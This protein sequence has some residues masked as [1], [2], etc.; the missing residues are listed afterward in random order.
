MSNATG[1][2]LYIGAYILLIAAL[3]PWLAAH[4]AQVINVDIAYLTLSAERLLAGEAMSEAYYDTNPPLSIILQIP[5]VI[6]VKLTHLPLYHAVSAYILLL[7]AL[8][9]TATY[10]LLQKITR[11]SNEQK[12]LIVSASL[13]TN[14]V[15]SG[16]DFGQKDHILAMALLPLTLLQILITQRINVHPALKWLT[17]L[18]GS[19]LILLKPHYGIIPA[20]IFLHR[21][22]T[23]KRLTIFK[24][25]DFLC[26]TLMAIAYIASIYIFFPDFISVIFP[27]IITFYAAD[28]SG[29]IV[30]T[31][32]LTAL[33]P[34][35][36][37]IISLL[38]FKD[39]P[40]LIP[41]I[42]ILSAF[43]FIPFIMQGKG[44][45]YHL[46]PA[47]IFFACGLSVL[48][49][50][51]M[52]AILMDIKSDK[53]KKTAS[54]AIT[55]IAI[56]SLA[57]YGGIAEK[58][59]PTHNEFRGLELTNIIEECAIDNK[60]NCPFLILHDMIN[61]SQELSIYTGQPHASRFPVMWFTPYL[62]NKENNLTSD[63]LKIYTDK[64]TN[65]IA[66]DFYKYSPEIIFVAHFPLPNENETIF[67]YRDYLLKN[68]PEF[69]NIWNNYDFQRT[70][71]IDRADYMGN[72]KPN[73]KLMRYDI[74]IRR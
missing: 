67:N 22:Y 58:I 27:D 56:L 41:S 19:V 25:H 47:I 18:A 55:F 69:K 52:R 30:T 15:A 42:F 61:I 38:I 54:F 43:C 37:S 72:K 34:L 48:F 7:L 24:D 17:L 64:Y 9:T 51:I 66:Q 28:I 74:Y 8:S 71:S 13:V 40:K 57:I 62:I 10:L 29:D 73:E 44:W 65:M 33:L 16:Y 68:N 3:L 23:Q 26:L 49:E 2:L 4:L 6:L 60:G 35:V 59:K 14:I 1:K 45:I 39:L 11:L 63:D 70:I 12:L 20:A 53:V 31:G 50:R 36:C 5:A 46:L 32:A 21:A